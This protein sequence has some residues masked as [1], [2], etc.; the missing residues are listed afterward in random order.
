MHSI[1]WTDGGLPF[2]I[3]GDILEMKVTKI[4]DSSLALDS[5]EKAEKKKRGLGACACK[6][7]SQPAICLVPPFPLKGCERRGARTPQDCR[8]ELP[9]GKWTFTSSQISFSVVQR[10]L[11]QMQPLNLLLF[12]Y[13]SIFYE[14]TSMNLCMPVRICWFSSTHS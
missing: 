6:M 8:M 7:P 9:F 4:I 13:F 14:G 1:K 10:T 2:I 12:N 11:N 5:G 3:H